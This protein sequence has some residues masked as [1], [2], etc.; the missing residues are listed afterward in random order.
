MS[1]GPALDVALRL[2]EQLDPPYLFARTLDEPDL[3]VPAPSSTPS[4]NRRSG[5]PWA[6]ETAF[7]VFSIAAG[8]LF[9]TILAGTFD[10]LATEAQ[11]AL[12]LLVVASFTVLVAMW[13]MEQ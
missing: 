4:T 9:G 11:Q 13:R 12:V 7:V 3:P 1:E 8:N 6:R 5:D 10:D 2:Q